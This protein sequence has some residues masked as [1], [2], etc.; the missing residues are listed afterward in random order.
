MMLL[1][2]LLEKSVIRSSSPKGR[3]NHLDYHQSLISR[4]THHLPSQLIH[5]LYQLLHHLSLQAS[6]QDY[7]RPH[8]KPHLNRPSLLS[9]PTI[10][11]TM[12]NM[13][14]YHGITI[15]RFRKN[16]RASSI[17][18]WNDPTKAGRSLFTARYTPPLSVLTIS[19][20]FPV[21]RPSSSHS[22]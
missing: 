17:I 8:L 11:T 3:R 9:P 4:K 16:Y 20:E 14:I 18:S 10:N 1:S 7:Q 6:P 15:H 21:Q 13:C 5:Q 2:M 19:A 12:S 22:S